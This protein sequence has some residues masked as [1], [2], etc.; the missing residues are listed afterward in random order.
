MITQPKIH[1]HTLT[2]SL[3]IFFFLDI[4][5]IKEIKEPVCQ[6]RVTLHVV[7]TEEFLQR[8]WLLSVC[9]CVRACMCECVHPCGGRMCAGA[10]AHIFPLAREFL[11]TGSLGC[12]AQVASAIYQGSQELVHQDLS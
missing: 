6:I 11:D 2:V 12:K 4:L 1:G 3:C 7:L 10:S 8:Q 9:A 5:S